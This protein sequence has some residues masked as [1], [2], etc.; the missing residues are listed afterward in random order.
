MEVRY[1]MNDTGKTFVDLVLAIQNRN[2]HRAELKEKELK[3][4][5]AMLA[6]YDAGMSIRELS[7]SVGV[8]TQRAHQMMNEVRYLV[9]ARNLDLDLGSDEL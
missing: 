7:G 5:I 2:R 9:E 4:K 6:A 1:N 3:L 8:S